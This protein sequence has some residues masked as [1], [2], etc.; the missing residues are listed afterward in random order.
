MDRT[1][2]NSKQ[3]HAN[4]ETVYN[5]FTTKDA[6]EF[7]LA[8]NGMTGEIHD[9]KLETGSGYDMSLFYRDPAIAGKTSGNED[10]FSAT[11]IELV[12]YEK[13][14]QA[15]RFK[16]DKQEFSEEMMMEVY[17][18][19]IN[20]QTTQVTIVFKNIP[21]GIDPKDNET[22]TEESLNKLAL[23]IENK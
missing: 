2:T 9:F 14:I 6:L 4:R 5:A 15:I 1:S 17:L 12:P 23:Y 19:A 18:E 11:F 8:P 20:E 7:W 3:I 21:D 22:G 13:I 16:S 10:R